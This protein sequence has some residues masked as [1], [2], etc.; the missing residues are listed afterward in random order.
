[1]SRDDLECNLE[2]FPLSL[3]PMQTYFVFKSKYICV[4][5]TH[6]LQKYIYK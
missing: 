5:T 2:Y 6:I 3:L 1:M 4:S